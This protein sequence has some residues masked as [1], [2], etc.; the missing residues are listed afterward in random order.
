MS[1]A[2][3]TVDAKQVQDMFAELE[4]RRRKQVFRAALNTSSNILIR[5]TRKNLAGVVK[6]PNSPNSWDGKKLQAGI[7]KRIARD[8]KSV[9]VHLLGDFRLK[10]FEMG[11]TERYTKRH[12]K[13]R[14]GKGGYRGKNTGQYFFRS[15]KQSTERRIFED[16]HSTLQR[17]IIRINK[18]YK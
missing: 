7:K 18:K 4:P 11:T 10:F 3:V 9:K 2:D 1:K 13:A 14:G 16:I 8:A 6:D 15:A 5:E 12:T 17:H